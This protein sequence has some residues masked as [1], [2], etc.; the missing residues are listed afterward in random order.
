MH[1]CNL[2]G[3]QMTFS[4]SLAERAK[5]TGQ[6]LLELKALFTMHSGCTLELRN[7]GIDGAIK[8]YP[9]SKYVK[10]IKDTNCYKPLLSNR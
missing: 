8:K 6:S 2:C 4:P 7:I 10:Q 1:T 5:K 9:K 3:K